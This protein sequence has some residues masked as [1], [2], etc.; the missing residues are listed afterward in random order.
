MDNRLYENPSAGRFDPPPP[1]VDPNA[2]LPMARRWWFKMLLVG[3]PFS[4]W[5]VQ[6]VHP[7]DR[8]VR[9][10]WVFVVIPLLILEAVVMRISAGEHGKDS[11]YTPPDRLTR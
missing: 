3:L 6:L 11:P 4:A 2:P 8:D 5:I 10:G 9:L 1:H 7:D